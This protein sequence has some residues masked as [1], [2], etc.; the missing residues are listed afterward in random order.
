MADLYYY[1]YYYYYYENS[2]G[3]WVKYTSILLLE[4]L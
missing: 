2:I 3:P 4:I 1:Y